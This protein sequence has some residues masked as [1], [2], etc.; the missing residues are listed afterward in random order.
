MANICDPI[1]AS[2]S[3]TGSKSHRPLLA[4]EASRNRNR[5]DQQD[6]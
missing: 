2:A 4:P 6:F 1:A 3:R 5:D